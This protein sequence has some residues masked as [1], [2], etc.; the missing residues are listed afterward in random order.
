MS[1]SIFTTL[2]KTIEHKYHTRSSVN[3]FVLPKT[4]PK[5]QISP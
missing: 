1:P 2:F 4:F 5:L 3:N